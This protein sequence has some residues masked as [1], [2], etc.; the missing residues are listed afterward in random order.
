MVVCS[1]WSEDATLTY[2]G[3]ITVEQQAKAV[4][5]G[6]STIRSLSHRNKMAALFESGREL[7]TAQITMKGGTTNNY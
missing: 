7:S 5:T 2:F 6:A 3:K 4:R 1:C